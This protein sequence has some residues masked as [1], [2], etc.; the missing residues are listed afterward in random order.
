[1]SPQ[2]TRLGWIGTGVMGASM[3][4]LLREA[5]YT[6]TV[7]NRTRAKAEPLLAIGAEWA[8]TPRAVAEASDV[9]FSIVGHPHDVR[10]V[11]LDE[12]TGVL[13]GSRAGMIVVD[14]TS[15]EPSLAVEAAERFAEKGAVSLDAPVSGGDV[16]ARDGKLS[17]MVG[18]DRAAF[19][20][21][22][23]LWRVMGAKWVYQG[24]A[25]AGQHTKV[26]NQTLAA[27]TMIGICESLV[28]AQK[29]GLD[30]D[31]V[32]ESVS[33][34]AAGSWSL[35]NLGPRIVRGDFAPGFY[36][37]HF[38][39]DLGV[40]LAEAERMGIELPGAAL[41]HRL[42]REV[43]KQGGGRK[44]TQSLVLA[45]AKINGVDWPEND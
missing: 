35:S 40:A 17:I 39:K 3:A 27:C 25:G 11:L 36:V 44:G 30:L 7:Y 37:E 26:V 21:L 41:A 28:Y 18:G 34:G 16:G 22:E 8:D 20:A 5:G 42:Y 2:E 33:S 23:P 43:E 32:L 13:A 29:A 45:L 14:M 10:E 1:M 31:T 38:I 19:D 9:V 4:R 15:S 12:T 24:A 6:V